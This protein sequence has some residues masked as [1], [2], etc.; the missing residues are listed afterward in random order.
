MPPRPVPS[1][2]LIIMG[3]LIGITL[4]AGM[5]SVPPLLDG[6]ATDLHLSRA[7]QGMLT[8]IMV[9]FVGLSAPFGQRLGARL[10]SERAMGIVLTVLTAG[11]LLRLAPGEV[12]A[13][14]LSSA[15]CGIGMGGASALLPSLIAHH[16][17]R[18][19]G[20]GMGVYSTGLASGV[21]LAAA[22]ALPSQELFG[23]WNIALALWAIPTAVITILWLL[24]IP[25]LRLAG[26]TDPDGPP[27]RRL[28]WRSATAWWV[29]GY[30]SAWMIIGFS[31]L[32]WV[33]PV[34]VSLGVPEPR[35]ATYFVI[36]QM[37]QLV[38]MLALPTLTDIT[39]DRRP[40]LALTLTCGL[41]GVFLLIVAP[42]P[43]AV[44]AVTLFGLGAGGGLTMSL[45]LIADVTTSQADGARVN[46]MSMLVA[47]PLG[48]LAPLMMG[49]LHDLTGTFATGYL[50][51]LGVT[52]VTLCGVPAFRPGRTLAG[53]SAPAL[54]VTGRP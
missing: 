4:R 16:A 25:R 39:S 29:T 38:S 48:A 20:L 42:V 3:G 49:Y 47:Y 51:I 41:V 33:M 54:A 7:T 31:G 8:S 6:I 40:L 15:I 27:D 30:T 18:V 52:V 44:P 12:W 11:F 5:G 26:D 9:L 53:P 37:V 24:L 1:A 35:A 43:M 28:P 13:F 36:F 21:G 45:V 50:V 46:A 22:L 32:A 23:D 14:Y 10:G 2:V 19:R 17:P 34:Y